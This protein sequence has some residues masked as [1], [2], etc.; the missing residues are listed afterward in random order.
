MAE[1]NVICLA[2]FHPDSHRLYSFFNTNKVFESSNFPYKEEDLAIK[3]KFNKYFDKDYPLNLA[4]YNDDTGNLYL[5]DMYNRLCI[6]DDNLSAAHWSYI[7]KNCS[8]IAAGA[9]PF[10]IHEDLCHELPLDFLRSIFDY[11]V[12][13]Y[14]QRSKHLGWEPIK[15][16]SDLYPFLHSICQQK[17]HKEI[18]E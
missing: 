5:A 18:L 9:H 6:P 17:Y 1:A 13:E 7:D 12:K 16:P 14:L 10:M 11:T 8:L 3:S 15:K 2:S 4:Y